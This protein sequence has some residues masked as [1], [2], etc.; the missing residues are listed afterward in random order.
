MCRHCRTVAHQLGRDVA[1]D[2]TLVNCHKNT[3]VIGFFSS[4]SFSNYL[5]ISIS[6]EYRGKI[7]RVMYFK[8]FIYYNSNIAS[9]VQIVIVFH[10]C[11]YLSYQ[12][13]LL[14]MITF[15]DEN[16]KENEKKNIFLQKNLV[17]HF[18]SD[19]SAPESI[20]A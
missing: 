8:L 13:S 20:A 11:F 19:L 5:Y 15:T 4:T 12:R 17:R 9:K 6:R 1:T 16:E 10:N 7:E 14:L 3:F 18:F 2:D